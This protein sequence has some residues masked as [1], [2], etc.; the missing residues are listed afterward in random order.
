MIAR[1][2]KTRYRGRSARSLASQGTQEPGQEAF[3]LY[4]GSTYRAEIT[5]VQQML[6]S[7]TLAA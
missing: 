2:Y 5:T 4:N 6:N 3:S 7:I 1:R